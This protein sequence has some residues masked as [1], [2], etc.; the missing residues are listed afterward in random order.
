M[1]NCNRVVTDE[2]VREVE[3]AKWSLSSAKS[4]SLV[5][6]TLRDNYGANGSSHLLAGFRQDP[7]PAPDAPVPSTRTRRKTQPFACLYIPPRA[8]RGE[9]N[10]QEEWSIPPGEY[11]EAET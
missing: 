8:F 2:K 7:A 3:S 6:V 9:L 5:T 10:V 1:L 11:F 4:V